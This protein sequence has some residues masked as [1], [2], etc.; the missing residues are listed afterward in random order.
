[1]RKKLDKKQLTAFEKVYKEK[2]IRDRAA[3]VAWNYIPLISETSEILSLPRRRRIV[4]SIQWRAKTPESIMRKLINKDLDVS[5]ESAVQNLHDIVG[6]RII[7]PYLDDVYLVTNTLK[8]IPGIKIVS[9]KN[10]IDHPKKS[11]YR[12]IHLIVDVSGRDDE[13]TR[14]EIQIRSVA[15]NIWADLE[16]FICYKNDHDR[17]TLLQRNFKALAEILSSVDWKMS[18]LRMQMGRI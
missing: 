4:S 11:G 1:M 13:I 15:M 10:Y 18:H 6:I 16:H 3:N 12:S 8:D 2:D 14:A 7:C 17:L 5:Y 9:E